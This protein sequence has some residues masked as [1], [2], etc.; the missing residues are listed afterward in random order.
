MGHF[1]KDRRYRQLSGISLWVGT[2]AP[3]LTVLI[4][5][6]W[7]LEIHSMLGLTVF[8]A[9]FLALMLT[10]GLVAV[11]INI[12]HSTTTGDRGVPWFDWL[13]AGCS[14]IVCSYIVINYRL[15]IHDLSSLVPIRLV[16]GIIMMML[17]GEATRRLFGW[18][19]LFICIFFIF[20][21]RFGDLMPG[22]FNLPESSWPRIIV[23]T[24]LDSNALLGLP[25]DVAANTIATFIL[26]GAFMKAAGGDRFI[27]GLAMLTMGRFRGGPAKVSV[28]A[29]TLFGTISGSAVSNIAVVGPITIPMMERTGYRKAEAAAIEAVSSTGGQIMPPVMGITAFLMADFLA[30]PYSQVITAALLPAILYYIALFIQIDLEAARQ[31]LKRMPRDEL[32]RLAA[33]MG[34]APIFLI[35]LL[36]IVYTMMF[37]FWPPGRAGLAA[38]ISIIAVQVLL[39]GH[40]LSLP[41]I[42]K[43]I[44]TTGQTMTDI[45]ILTAMAGIIIGSIQLSGIGFAFSSTLPEL[46]GNNP[47]FSLIVTGLLCVILGMA[48]PTA[49]IYTTL[50]VIIAPALVNLGIDQMTA[51]LFIFYMGMLSM[52]TPPVCFATYT[53]AAIAGSNLWPTA[54]RS[55]QYGCAAYIIPF[56]LPLSPG[57]LMKGSC[58]QIGIAFITAVIGIAAIAIALVGHLFQRIHP[59]NRLALFVC[60]LTATVSPFHSPTTM[61]ANTF[62]IIG[63][64]ILIYRE[65]LAS[66]VDFAAE[67]CRNFTDTE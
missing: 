2:T 21:A 57:L 44:L 13:F 23:Y 47:F 51:H 3:V 22:I 54:L 66:N 14:I 24:Y 64:G 28:I 5:C 1:S 4:A 16:F 19:L 8:K 7:I 50:A 37:S 34:T 31:G 41:K 9:Q 29:S 20:C 48:L 30:I 27:T 36:I 39:P 6:A 15:L 53:A 62:A 35:P 61:M 59:Y 10:S 49:V 42:G 67:R 18:T 63:G 46:T 33:I 12:S 55:M 58:V 32:P 17:I 25:L 43:A 60:G 38:A 52:L 45:L 65:W 56:I 40:R 26:F 11:F